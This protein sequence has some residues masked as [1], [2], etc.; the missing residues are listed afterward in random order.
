MGGSSCGIRRISARSRR[1][2]CRWRGKRSAARSLLRGHH[3]ERFVQ[4]FGS[5]R[6]GTVDGVAGGSFRRFAWC[7]Q[8]DYT[9]WSYEDV[10]TQKRASSTSSPRLRF[11]AR[12]RNAPLSTLYWTAK[13][14]YRSRYLGEPYIYSNDELADNCT[15]WSPQSMVT[16]TSMV[17]WFSQQGPYSYDGTSILPVQ[18]TVRAWIDDDIDLLNVRA[19]SHAV[20]LYFTNFGGWGKSVE[21]WVLLIRR[22]L[23][24]YNYKEGFWSQARC[25]Y[26]G[27]R[28]RELYVAHDHGER[29]R[30]V[31]A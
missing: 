8:E 11:S 18:C 28:D 10:T 4:I 30:L 13:K 26:T 3:S 19:T 24:I 9:N 21:F 16:T 5:Y 12:G 22:V 2:L 14:C 31:R 17:L 27:R 23:W 15:P 20:S 25:A 1:R 6:D 29:D 7:E